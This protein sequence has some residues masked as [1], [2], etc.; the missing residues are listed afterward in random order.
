M[1]FEA[2]WLRHVYDPFNQLSLSAVRHGVISPLKV[3]PG[4]AIACLQ[5][6]DCFRIR[7]CGCHELCSGLGSEWDRCSLRQSRRSFRI[8]LS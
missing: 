8:E 2:G 6:R 3:I 5:P 7:K 1:K 4:Q